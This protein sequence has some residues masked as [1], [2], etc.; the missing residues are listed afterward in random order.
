MVSLIYCAAIEGVQAN[1]IEVEA[2]IS[3]G[4][5]AFSIVGLADTAV[6][7]SRDRV[8]AALKNSGYI[9]PTQKI[10]VN[11]APADTKKEGGA[12]DLP[13]A[14]AILACNGAIKKENLSNFCAIGELALNGQLR[15]IRGA[16]PISLSLRNTGKELIVP[17]A[18]RQEASVIKEVKVYPFKN[19]TQV[20][21][22]INGQDICQPFVYKPDEQKSNPLNDLDFEDVKGQFGARR[23]AEISAAGFHNMIMSGP[24]GAGK[25][26]IALRMPAILPPMNFEES[27]ETTKIWSVAGKSFSGGLITDRPFRSPHHTTS[28]V[29]LAGGG[30]IPKPGEVSLA[31]N[32]ILFLD[33]FA[34]FRRDSLEILRQPLEDASITISRA[35]SVLTF[36]AAFM[37][38]AAMNPCPCGHFGDPLKQCVCSQV[39]IQR[40]QNKISGPLLDRI[41]LHVNVNA[42]KIAE[43]TSSAKPAESSQAIRERVI[44]ARKIQAERFVNLNIHS[45]A[46]MHSKQIKQYCQTDDKA[47]QALSRAIEKLKLSARAYDRIL[48]VSRT[49]ADLDNSEIIKAVHIAEAVQYRFF[50]SSNSRL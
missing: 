42:L 36:P 17:F 48:K 49:I 38:V 35:K 8:F 33:E 40:Y 22:F 1:I 44:K 15:R 4:L 43:L 20:V 34:E 6:K 41:D 18:N 30:Q 12:F 3:P 24:P 39:Q 14:L 16:L 31:H 5:P 10:T 27:I 25:T 50:E 9:F 32:G 21:D 11:L 46:K 26:M 37:L 47:K 7:E 19:L 13:I 28:C 45:N 2:Y 23:A 29:A